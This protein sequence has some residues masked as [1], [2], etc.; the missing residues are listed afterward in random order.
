MGIF[1]ITT[2]TATKT[3]LEKWIC[4][5]SISIAITPNHLLCQMQAN[6]FWAEFLRTISSS[7]RE[8]KFSRCLFTSMIKREI[9][10]FPVVV[11]QWR[12]RN[13]QKSVMHVQCCCLDYSTYCFFDVL[14]VVAVV[15]SYSLPA[16]VRWGSFVTHS[17][18]PHGPY[19]ITS[20]APNGRMLAFSFFKTLLAWRATAFQ[21][22][23]ECLRWCSLC[24]RCLFR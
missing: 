21:I 24:F 4:V 18:L 13:V 6:P 3:S 8:R 7:E 9:R 20:G 11:V 1:Y 12:Q 23:Q 19:L 15:A 17:F 5:L 10:H 14:V 22:R 16:D 2:V